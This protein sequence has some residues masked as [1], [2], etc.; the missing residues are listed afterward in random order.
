M[1]LARTRAAPGSDSN[2]PDST[3]GCDNSINHG[4]P[5]ARA[6]VLS[7]LFGP[8]PRKQ[9]EWSG[10][11]QG[12][13]AQVPDLKVHVKNPGDFPT[14]ENAQRTIVGECLRAFDKPFDPS[15]LQALAERAEGPAQKQPIPDHECSSGRRCRRPE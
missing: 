9:T 13:Q 11:G 4:A 6:A 2:A 14:D 3:T 12:L 5:L 15:V 1:K 8:K 10:L 7:S